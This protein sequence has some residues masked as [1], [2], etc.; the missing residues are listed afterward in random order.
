MTGIQRQFMGG[1][2]FA[3]YLRAPQFL[4][5]LRCSKAWMYVAV[6]H[7]RRAFMASVDGMAEYAFHAALRPGEDA[8]TW[9]EADARRVFT[10]AVGAEVPSAPSDIQSPDLRNTLD[11]LLTG[12]PAPAPDTKAF[13]CSI[14]RV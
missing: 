7:Q 2:M 9:T 12:K 11:A 6:N 13:G 10:E 1:K 3:V 14:K 8:E 4:Q 5:V